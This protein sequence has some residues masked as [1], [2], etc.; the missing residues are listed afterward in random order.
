[1]SDPASLSALAEATGWSVEPGFRVELRG[2]TTLLEESLSQ[3]VE[4][5]GLWIVV[6]GG[7]AEPGSEAESRFV[8]GIIPTLFWLQA[9]SLRVLSA[10]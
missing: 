7:P 4:I 6:P 3:E 1:V 8:G 5:Q 10:G 9:E 2:D